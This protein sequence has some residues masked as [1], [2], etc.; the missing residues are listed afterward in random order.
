MQTRIA[1]P[2]S[3]SEKYIPGG[4]IVVD[5]PC[6]R[7]AAVMQCRGAQGGQDDNL[8]MEESEE[9][10]LWLLAEWSNDVK[11]KKLSRVKDPLGR[12]LLTQMLCRNP[13]KRPTLQRVL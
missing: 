3:W 10:S 1:R 5:V 13:L 7:W 6:D 4:A 8:S 12:N 9:D 11:Y 2:F